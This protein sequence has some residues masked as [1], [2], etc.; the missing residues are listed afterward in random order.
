MRACFVVYFT[1]PLEDLASNGRSTGEYRTGKDLIGSEYCLIKILCVNLSGTL[2]ASV[3][4]AA[5]P[6]EIRTQHIP[7]ALP[8]Y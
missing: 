3:T 1:T 4:V 2:K 5:V 8:L 7:R 6:A